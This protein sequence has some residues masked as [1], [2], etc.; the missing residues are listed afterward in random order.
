MSNTE[1]LLRALIDALGYEVEEVETK[2]SIVRLSEL[3]T[4][5]YPDFILTTDYKVTK[6]IT[7]SKPK[8]NVYMDSAVESFK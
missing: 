6:K 1:K 2:R 8:S 7:K 4:T 3:D 5:P